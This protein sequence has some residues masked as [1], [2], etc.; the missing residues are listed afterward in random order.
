MY[1]GRKQ[2]IHPIALTIFCPIK[3]AECFMFL[4]FCSISFQ[5]R[6]SKVVFISKQKKRKKIHN[7]IIVY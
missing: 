5:A 6:F 2:W 1:T 4:L 7:L 3:A